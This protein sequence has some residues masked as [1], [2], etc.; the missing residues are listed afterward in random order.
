MASINLDPRY[1]APKKVVIGES[2]GSEAKKVVLPTDSEP[3]SKG[4]L[5]HG[6]NANEHV[7]SMLA[8]MGL[9]EKG[10]PNKPVYKDPERFG[11]NGQGCT[12][13]A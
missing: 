12:F 8:R 5:K 13:A 10:F 3:L 1:E 2:I 11:V 4:N 7:V 6:S 9:T